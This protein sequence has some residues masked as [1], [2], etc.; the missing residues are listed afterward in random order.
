MWTFRNEPVYEPSRDWDRHCE[1]E[2]RWLAKR[3]ACDGC[4]EPIVEDYCYFVEGEYLCEDCMKA[5][6]IEETPVIED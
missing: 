1:E 6:Y 3:K 5:R 2:E 4:G